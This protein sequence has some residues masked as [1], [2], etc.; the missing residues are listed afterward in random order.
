MGLGASATW[1]LLLAVL[2]ALIAGAPAAADSGRDP[3]VGFELETPDICIKPEGAPWSQKQLVELKHRAVGLQRGRWLQGK[4]WFLGAD[5]QSTL[6]CLSL[7]Y[8][9]RAD[10]TEGGANLV[11]LLGRM[12]RDAAWA[13]PG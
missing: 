5:V 8:D 2:S 6:R 4:G 13:T 9:L 3:V 1:R 11:A 12:E 7:E 10:L